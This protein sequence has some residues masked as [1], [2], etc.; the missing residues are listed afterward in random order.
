M[1]TNGIIISFFQSVPGI[2][3]TLKTM[4]TQKQTLEL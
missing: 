2:T 4:L 3:L 1:R